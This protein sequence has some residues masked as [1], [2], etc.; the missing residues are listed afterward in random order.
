MVYHGKESLTW[1]SATGATAVDTLP[2]SGG[3]TVTAGQTVA[4]VLDPAA[5]TSL[6]NYNLNQLKFRI[7]RYGYAGAAAPTSRKDFSFLA[8]IGMPASS[9]SKY[10]DNGF[11]IPGSDTAFHITESKNGAKAWF[12]AQLL[13]LMR[14]EGLPEYVMG[15]PLALLWF[16]APILLV[17]RHHIVIR[18][19]G[20]A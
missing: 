17:P 16:A 13:P 1:F 5:I 10:V 14:R 6:S 4:L 20:R 15:S 3:A 8:E 11:S 7:Y 19:I 2:T 9:T 12:M 18:N